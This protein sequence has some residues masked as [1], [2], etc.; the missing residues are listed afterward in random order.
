M[1]KL[2]LILMMIAGCNI[3]SSGPASAQVK[4]TIEKVEADTAIAE[5]WPVLKRAMIRITLRRLLF[6]LAVSAREPF[7]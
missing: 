1:R 4:A 3:L 5:A 6:L 7:L 2:R